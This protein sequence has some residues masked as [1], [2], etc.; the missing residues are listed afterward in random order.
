MR[1]IYSSLLVFLLM[2]VST[3]AK[4]QLASTVEHYPTTD[5]STKAAVYSLSEIAAALG[6]DAATLDNGFL[7]ALEWAEGDNPAELYISHGDSLSQN[8][9]AN[10]YGS[11]WMTKEGAVTEWGNNSV[12]FCDFDWNVN[13]DVF[14]AYV[15]QFPEALSVGDSFTFDYVITF[16]G[17]QVTLTTT[18]NIIERPTVSLKDLDI[19]KEYTFTLPFVEGKYYEGKTYSATLDGIYDALGV[20]AEEFDADVVDY[21]Y[22]E[23][24][25]SEE[26][27]GEMAY[28]FLED[29]Q[30]IADA[31]ADGWFGRYGAYD[32]ASGTEVVWSQNGP[33]LWATGTNT[34]Y[35]QTIKL[36]DG[37]FSLVSGQY[38]GTMSVDDS[39][40]VD[41]YIVNGNKAV[42][43][44]VEAE[45]SKPEVVDPSQMVKVGETTVK[46]SADIDNN[47]AT[48]GFTID[49]EAIVEALGCT[50]DDL[51][52]LYA[53]AAEGELSD[54][55]TE[56]SGGYYFNDQGYIEAWG[57]NA[58]F[59]IAVTSTT[60][61][62][63]NYTIGQMAN[64]FTDIT[65]DTTV[66][67]QIVFQYG[68]K[69]YAVNIE[70]TV[71][72][73]GSKGDDF[74]YTLVSTEGINMQIIPRDVYEWETK[75]SLDLEY[76]ENKIGT[77]EFTLYTD[78]YNSA[79]ETL[80][81]SKNYTCTPAPGFW[82][83]VS[84]YENAEHQV[85]VTNAG[86][87][88]NSFG[89]TYAGGTITWYQYPGQRSV[90]D[91]FVANLYLV[92]EE[93]G[94]YIKYVLQVVYVDEVRPE[95]ETVLRN[96]LEV[97]VTDD[98]YEGG[99]FVHR[100]DTEELFAA[101]GITDAVELEGAEFF[102]AKSST[103][104][105]ALDPE[106]LALF[107]ADG[108]LVPE[109]GEII[110]MAGFSLEDGLQILFDPMELDFAKGDESKAV[111]RLAIE[112]NGKR[113]L[114]IIT[115]LSEDSPLS[116]A[117]TTPSQKAAPAGV[118]S[119]SGARLSAPQKGINIVKMSDGSVQKVLV[120]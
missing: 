90:G 2:A 3:V 9:T 114:Y 63:G 94:K 15:G 99:Y 45:V 62:N 106:D 76:I 59:F 84:E 111:A 82:Y 14:Y 34:F 35:L 105:S 112:Y 25:L 49:M 5:Y 29:L 73:P 120:K 58:A 100:L 69:Y 101:L 117:A 4:A 22:T 88:T 10:G 55:H 1:K 44:K 47:Y 85:V 39:D 89:I 26:V 109:T 74:E 91:S 57:S 6:T 36:A 77:T 95:A 83:G 107:G 86:W 113:A 72:V 24:I 12:V 46:V 38:P 68:A 7:V 93:N 64:H 16:G 31:A 56:G 102:A 43:V 104:Y 42:K 13:D 33:M 37:E 11:S 23:P 41:L 92:N 119:I 51:D 28:T 54:N 81:W 67:A 27:D 118:Y 97:T 52:D 8:W 87:G 53:W 19:V 80:E 110:S 115:F 32:E 70:Y 40:Y 79:T 103:M 96:E 21:I 18:L 20:T 61:A 60:L 17:K 50:T 48:K 108:Y 116:I 65:E 66:T 78:V 30:N 71:K 75:S 98:G